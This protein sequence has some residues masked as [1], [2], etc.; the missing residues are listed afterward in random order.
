MELILQLKRLGKKKFIA[1]LY[2]R[3]FVPTTL[4]T[5][6]EGCAAI[7]VA[8]YIQMRG[9]VELLSFRDIFKSA[10]S[11]SSFCQKHRAISSW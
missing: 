2:Q 4:Q 1:V 6:I 8:R 11:F 9:E 10:I 5:L 7:E 3:P